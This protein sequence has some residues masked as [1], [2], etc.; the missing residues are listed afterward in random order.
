MLIHAYLCTET[1]S[2]HIR[3]ED[4]KNS[5]H[6]VIESLNSLQTYAAQYKDRLGSKSEEQKKKEEDFVKSYLQKNKTLSIQEQIAETLRLA[7][8]KEDEKKKLEQKRQ[9]EKEIVENIDRSQLEFYSMEIETIDRIEEDVAQFIADQIKMERD[10][11]ETQIIIE[12]EEKKRKEKE[13]LL[14]H[15]RKQEE[16]RKIKLA[17]ERAKAE[18]EM[19]EKIMR[20]L[21]ILQSSAKKDS[22]RIK[23]DEKQRESERLKKEK[24]EQE[25]EELKQAE[26]K[27]LAELEKINLVKEEAKKITFLSA[28]KDFV[29][30]KTNIKKKESVKESSELIGNNEESK[31]EA[32]EQCEKLRIMLEHDRQISMELQDKRKK[33]QEKL[34]LSRRQEDERRAQLYEEVKRLENEKRLKQLEKLENESK[35]EGES[36]GNKPAIERTMLL[37][38]LHKFEQLSKLAKEEEVVIKRVKREKKRLQAKSKSKLLLNKVIA[39]IPKS[40]NNVSGVN[41]IKNDL[42]ST[43]DEMKNYLIS[44]ILFDEG[45]G[46]HSL[47]KEVIKSQELKIK[48]C[49]DN[50]LEL[51]S[52]LFETYK[53]NMEEYLGIV[54]E[55]KHYD[56]GCQ[57]NKVS[58][59]DDKKIKPA[60]KSTNKLKEMFKSEEPTQN[61]QLKKNPM[62]NVGLINFF[63]SERSSRNA[64][65]CLAQVCLLE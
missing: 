48:E 53:Q 43:K 26:K 10:A 3:M 31:E 51:E 58:T 22:S 27:R 29:K 1:L 8:I 60:L 41:E 62:I 4:T 19:K 37:P 32:K 47:E 63:G 18:Q 33:E 14:F 11:R 17:L 56:Q 39:S 24:E 65:V 57:S 35:R 38:L 45:E 36:F 5:N 20:E 15:L 52:K 7:K 30:Q 44:H 2:T 25:K 16:E 46:V 9:R 64:N 54:C 23:E 34:A 13:E 28:M 59:F 61:E 42:N 49:Q 12:R 40:L 55:D 6:A 21:Q 50:E